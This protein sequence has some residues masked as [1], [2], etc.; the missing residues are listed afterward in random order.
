MELSLLERI[1]I[2]NVL[3][4]E[5]DILTLRLTQDIL[6]KVEISAQEIEKFEIVGNGQTITWNDKGT[7]SKK[8]VIFTQAEI[9]LV[10]TKVAKLD[11]EKKLTFQMLSLHEKFVEGNYTNT[12]EKDKKPKPDEGN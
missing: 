8:E 10:K 12:P 4:K 11:S 3:P 2:Q 6:K 7:K 9:Q 5:G 1:Q